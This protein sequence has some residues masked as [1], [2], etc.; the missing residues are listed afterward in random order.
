MLDFLSCILRNSKNTTTN[1]IFATNKTE[2][3]YIKF[4]QYHHSLIILTFSI[5]CKITFSAVIKKRRGINAPE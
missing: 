4:L 3:L 1:M 5:C 2:R